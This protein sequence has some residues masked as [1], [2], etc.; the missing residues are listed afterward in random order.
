MAEVPKPATALNPL[1]TTTQDLRSLKT[2]TQ[3][4]LREYLS[5]QRKRDRLEGAT[6]L[7]LEDQIRAQGRVVLGD[8][9]TLRKEVGVVI[10]EGENHRWR[11]WLIGGAV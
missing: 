10:K 4:A 1:T 3:F 5:L 11:N 6:S 9:K 7:E 2:S 8:L